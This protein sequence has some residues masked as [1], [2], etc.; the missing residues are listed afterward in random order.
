M[1][2]PVARRSPTPKK[3]PKR[4]EPIDKAK[5]AGLAAAS[6]W[7]AWCW[8]ADSNFGLVGN[9]ILLTHEGGHPLFGIFGRFL[10]TAGGTLMQLLVPTAFIVNFFFRGQLLSTSVGFHWLAASLF[11]CS[12]YAADA[13]DQDLPLIHTGMSA[14]EELETYG[15]TE[16]DWINML[17]MLHLPLKAAGPIAA[18][19]T[20]AAF[21]AWAAGL[22]LGLR[23]AGCPLP[24]AVERRLPAP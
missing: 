12:Q 9:F 13:I 5:L 4:R 2:A 17:D 14:R 24:A 6:A 11:G 16:H 3:R 21:A 22:V 1:T 19:F 7:L 23:A 18:L 15:E 20:L 10:G 8:H